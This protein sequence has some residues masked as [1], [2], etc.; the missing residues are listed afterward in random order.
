[1][2]KYNKLQWDFWAVNR[3]SR[4]FL[5]VLAFLLYERLIHLQA[6]FWW[7]LIDE[8]L[9][10]K[11]QPKKSA[12][13]QINSSKKGP[14][15]AEARDSVIIWP[16]I[17]GQS[18]IIFIHFWGRLSL[19]NIYAVWPLPLASKPSLIPIFNIIYEPHYSIIFSIFSVAAHNNIGLWDQREDQRI[20]ALFIRD[21]IDCWALIRIKPGK[22]MKEMSRP[23]KDYKIKENGTWHQIKK[24]LHNLPGVS[25]HRFL[26]QPSFFSYYFYGPKNP[27]EFI[28]SW[29]TIFT[30]IFSFEYRWISCSSARQ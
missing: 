2:E 8:P 6:Y 19:A 30:I 21:F 1:M 20:R 13:H 11:Y 3:I 29:S 15:R 14:E 5:L 26:G 22:Y 16:I 4:S 24:F 27:M 10:R 18:S 23:D 12:A 28:S 25:F 7:D 17:G 9:H